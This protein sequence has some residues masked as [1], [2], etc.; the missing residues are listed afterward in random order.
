[1]AQRKLAIIALDGAEPSLIER[2]SAEGH[3]PA[4]KSM[5]DEG[6]FGPLCSVIPPVTG[7]AWGSFVTGVYPGRH[8]IF[9]WL[10]RG[11]D[12][13]R[14]SLVNSTALPY[15]TI[16]EWLSQNGIRVGTM[17]VPLSYPIR[18]VSGF[19]VSDL[20][21]PPGEAYTHPSE[22][23]NNIEDVLGTRYPLAPPPWLGRP[24]AAQWFESLKESLRLR[25]KATLHLAESQ[26]WDLFMIHVMETDS[27]Q[28][29]MW[30][31]LD[32]HK[33]RRYKLSMNGANP[34]LEIYQ[35]ADQFVGEL[36]SKLSDETDIMIISDHGFGP[37]LKNLHLNTWLMEQGF[38]KVRSN[39][40]TKFKRLAFSLGLVPENLYP[41]EENL[42]LLGKAS[43]GGQAYDI[44]S[45]FV[46]STQ[47]IDWDKTVAY[48]Y[49]NVGQIY[50]NRKGREPRGIVEDSESAQTLSQLEDA[51][52]GW[53]DP[54]TGQHVVD[55]V[56]RTADIYTEKALE[57]APDLVF[58]PTDGYSPMGLSEFLSNRTITDP[59]A[60][61]GWHRMN[62]IYVGH[63]PSLTPGNKENLRLIDLFPAICQLMGIEPPDHIDGVI[64]EDILTKHTMRES[65]SSTESSRY[66]AEAQPVLTAAEE[67]ELRDR[68]K[69]LGY[70]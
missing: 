62:G 25:T 2:W 46:L 43:S 27:V 15:P 10:R 11:E 12:T 45:K 34:I 17:S 14:L 16:F 42:R 51:L 23:Q 19:V 5:I 29:Q 37:H 60:H 1:M 44:M 4:I 50:L 59:V 31:E 56:Y 69:G 55:S 13:Y 63:G 49:G 70:L 3:L 53:V 58:L 64:P 66:R 22:L 39:A 61:S 26:D 67:E 65:V 28:H 9:E 18:P 20:L 7:A 48:S 41:I 8:G 47:N 35:M 54:Q 36:R 21:T 52:K 40:A 6:S 24:R 33:R 57:H 30:Q 32:D 68:L 38:L